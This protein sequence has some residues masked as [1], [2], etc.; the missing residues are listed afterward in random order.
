MYFDVIYKNKTNDKINTI[1]NISFSMLGI[2]N[3]QNALASISIAL[4]L[5]IDPNIIKLALKNFKGVQRRFQLI[6]KFKNT[7]IIDDYGHKK[8]KLTRAY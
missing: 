7:K 3:I 2:H 4:E 6:D 1:K 5:N 8:L